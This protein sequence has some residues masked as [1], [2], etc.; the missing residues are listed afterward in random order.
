MIFYPEQNVCIKRLLRI[1]LHVSR[2]RGVDPMIAIF[3]HTYI[4]VYKSII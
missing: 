4:H 1:N 3:I 2:E